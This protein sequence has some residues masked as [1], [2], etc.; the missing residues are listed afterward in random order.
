MLYLDYSDMGMR[1]DGPLVLRA[2]LPL[3]V[4]GS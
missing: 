1:L 2:D 4:L 3:L